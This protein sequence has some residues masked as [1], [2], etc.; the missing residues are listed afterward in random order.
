MSGCKEA[1]RA[2]AAKAQRAFLN[3]SPCGPPASVI[4]SQPMLT[5]ELR[6]A[7][8]AGAATTGATRSADASGE[9]AASRKQRYLS[10]EAKRFLR[11]YVGKKNSPARKR[12]IASWH[13]G[14]SE[15]RRETAK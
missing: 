9:A 10:M 11:R 13:E 7:R 6:L 12:R 1:T 2:D 4:H 8:A 14:Y 5:G 15:N 3:L